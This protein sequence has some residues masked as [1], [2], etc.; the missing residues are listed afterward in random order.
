[1]L[2][3]R[4]ISISSFNVPHDNFARSDLSIL[5]RLDF[6]SVVDDLSLKQI[7]LRSF[8]FAV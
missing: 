1:M 2:V 6:T 7:K 3:K 5:Q 8:D 4:P